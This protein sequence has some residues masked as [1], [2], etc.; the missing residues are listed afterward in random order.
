M[1]FTGRGGVEV[2]GG[3]V[4]KL[5]TWYIAGMAEEVDFV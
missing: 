4:L 3:P 5:W 2:P 1:T